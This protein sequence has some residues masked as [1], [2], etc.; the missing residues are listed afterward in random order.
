MFKTLALRGFRGF[1]SYTLTDLAPVNLIVG[2]NN[3]GKT[4]VLE[5]VQ[6][7]A[8]DGH[9]A[10]LSEIVRRR[11]EGSYRRRVDISH[12]FFGHECRSGAQFE[13]SSGDGERNV[14]ARILALDEVGE[15]AVLW[16]PRRV[17]VRRG[18]PEPDEDND[19]EFALRLASSIRKD[20]RMLPVA[21][22]GTLLYEL[23]SRSAYNEGSGAPVRF[24]GLES[25]ADSRMSE[26]WDEI[27]AEGREEEIAEDMRL[28]VP[29][30]DSVHFLSGG[31]LSGSILVGR[32]GGGRRLPIGSF[33]EGLRRLLALRLALVGATGGFLL[34]DE[35]D[36]GLHWTVIQDVWRLLVEVATRS[37]VQIFATTH[38][39]DCIRG[40][41]MLVT[42]R[43][44]LAGAVSIQKIDES[45]KQAVALRGEQIE[46]AVAQ[47]IEVR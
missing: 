13:L 12:L 45:L 44:D 21:R 10:A 17:N 3:C 33:G 1:E 38:S 14:H 26:A 22:D 43:P 19:P 4:S 25:A 28:L 9:T 35:I 5:A 7:L 31:R 47:E 46:I 23:G 34:L 40:L 6:L 24:L 36:S 29:E 30:I 42:S 16:D 18:E 15:E 8:S 27:L 37:E 39:Y 20:P 2:K 41:G 32:R 11:R